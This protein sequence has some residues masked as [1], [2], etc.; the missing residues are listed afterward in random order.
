MSSVVN[1]FVHAIRTRSKKCLAQKVVNLGSLV[2]PILMLQSPF[3]SSCVTLQYE[4][5]AMFFHLAVP[6]LRSHT[7][8]QYNRVVFLYVL[9]SEVAED[10]S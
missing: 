1:V 9:Y 6:K 8:F 4:P 7:N 2:G 10:Y 3:N 5:G